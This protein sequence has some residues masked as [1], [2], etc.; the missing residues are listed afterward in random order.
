MDGLL[1]VDKSAGWTSFDVVAKVRSILRQEIS[2]QQLLENRGKKL[3]ANSSLLVTSSPKVRVGHTGTLDPFATG[4]LILVLGKYTKRAGQF[5]EMDKTYEAELVLGKTST[6]GDPEGKILQKSD[7]KP[8]EDEVRAV[9]KGFEGKILQK[10]HK[11]SAIKIG[12]QRAYKMARQGK[13]VILEPRQ[14]TVYSLQF[15]E[16]KYPKLKITTSVSSGTYI[17]S[18]AEDIGQKLGTGAYLSELRRTRVGQFDIKDAA[19][20][21]QLNKANLASRLVKK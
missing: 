15:T 3:I 16:Y 12:G 13:E 5:S 20:L 2:K 6:T 7:K 10:P 9:L 1:L 4:L 14:V 11:Y 19:R 18:L 17:R 8:T 21:D